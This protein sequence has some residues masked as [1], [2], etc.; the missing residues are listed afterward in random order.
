MSE[1]HT[2]M[3]LGSFFNINTPVYTPFWSLSP[4]CFRDGS[5]NVQTV[6]LVSVA[7]SQADEG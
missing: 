5:A 2:C 6:Y 7:V 3:H 1:T 4:C